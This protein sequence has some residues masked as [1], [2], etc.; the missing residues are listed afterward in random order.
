VEYRSR[1]N[2]QVRL[3]TGSG[4]V[5]GSFTTDAEEAVKAQPYAVEILSASFSWKS[6]SN[7]TALMIL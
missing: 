2:K 1:S 6:R 7:I 3:E 5:A 4:K